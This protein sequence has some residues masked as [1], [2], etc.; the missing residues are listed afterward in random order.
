[1]HYI[2]LRILLAVLIT[3]II[4]VVYCV[5]LAALPYSPISF[6]RISRINTISLVPEGWAF[7]TRDARE[8]VIIVYKKTPT[9]IWEQV[10]VPGASA[11][12]LFGLDR[13]GRAIGVELAMLKAA[14]ADST[15][16]SS[17]RPLSAHFQRDTLPVQHLK[18]N[19]AQPLCLGD[20]I[21]QVTPPVPWSW[22]RNHSKVIMPY[23]IA[24]LYVEN[25]HR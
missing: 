14:I 24:R 6:G 12:Y 11:R 1:M 19:A 17:R 13:K 23:K 16:H 21:V 4:L 3:G 15:W 25:D 20:I 5:A 18:N 9:G 7:F 22:A 10:N 2:R 8:D